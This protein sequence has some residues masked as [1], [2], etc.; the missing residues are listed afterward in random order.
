MGSRSVSPSPEAGG[1]KFISKTAPSPKAAVRTSPRASHKTSSDRV[2]TLEDSN[3]IELI[4]DDV[5]S[6]DDVD[7]SSDHRVEIKE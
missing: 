5:D 4:D 7:S 6:A 1:R 2:R 3:V